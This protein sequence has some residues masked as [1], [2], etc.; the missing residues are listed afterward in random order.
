MTR[1]RV[2]PHDAKAAEYERWKSAQRETAA[3]EAHYARQADAARHATRAA[4]RDDTARATGATQE[5][6]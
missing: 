4:E 6:N 5:S 3:R 1:R 2:E